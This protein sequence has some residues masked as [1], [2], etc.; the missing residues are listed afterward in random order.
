MQRQIIFILTVVVGRSTETHSFSE[1][2]SRRERAMTCRR[3]CSD[4]FTWSCSS[5]RCCPCSWSS[6]CPSCSRCCHCHWSS[7]SFRCCWNLNQ[8]KEDEQNNAKRS[9]AIVLRNRNT[10]NTHSQWY[11]L[12]WLELLPPGVEYEL[13]WLLVPRGMVDGTDCQRVGGG[14]ASRCLDGFFL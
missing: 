11:E 8:K 12:P 14:S 13:P 2:N 3:H 1:T 5:F 4:F 7:S 6:R 10:L 9:F